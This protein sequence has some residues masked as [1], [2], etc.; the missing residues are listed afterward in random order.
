[1]AFVQGEPE[2]AL[3]DAINGDEERAGTSVPNFNNEDLRTYGMRLEENHLNQLGL[4]DFYRY[5]RRI[6]VPEYTRRGISKD[7]D[8]L[9]A[10]QAIAGDIHSQIRDEYCAGLWRNDLLRQLCWKSQSDKNMPAVKQSPSWS[11]LSIRGPIVPC[12]GE[13]TEDTKLS[14][15][16]SL[17][18]VGIVEVHCG[19]IN[20]S[21]YGQIVGGR[22]KLHALALAVQAVRNQ[23]TGLVEFGQLKKDSNELVL[24]HP[25][26][27][28]FPDTP[29]KC[30]SRQPLLRCKE[31]DHD[32]PTDHIEFPEPGAQAVSLLV[33]QD[34]MCVLVRSPTPKTKVIRRVGIGLCQLEG[35]NIV[36]FRRDMTL[37]HFE[38]E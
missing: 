18:N 7:E 21:P 32:N 15:N 25:Q 37:R 36:H 20:S 17:G 38:L 24:I 22:I 26:L 33:Q 9:V 5:W 35:S 11:W 4:E 3:Q 2:S 6:L 1:M 13:H 28:F 14:G 34:I 12:L 27:Q 10:L 23:D 16:K 19:T 8:R 30:G 29:L 31:A